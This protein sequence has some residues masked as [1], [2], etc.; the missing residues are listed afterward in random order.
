M[1]LPSR[2]G[3]VHMALGFFFI[4]IVVQ[5]ARVQLVNGN[6][7]QRRADRQQVRERE[8]P[9]PRG[10]ILDESGRVM[11]QNNDKVRLDITPREVRERQKLEGILLRARVP[12]PIVARIRDQ[13]LKNVTIPGT[14]L[15]ID[16]AGALGMKGVHVTPFVERAYSASR[17]ARQ[18]IGRVGQDGQ[19]IDGIELS[20]D[21]ILKGKPGLATLVQDVS[22]RTFE[23]PTAP[24]ISPAEGNTV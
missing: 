16:V 1:K 3:V 8:I 10:R 9:A 17:A 11:A 12:S 20:L 23:S 19:P 4:A 15:R 2:L 18:I 7:W 22:R 5:A 24:G 21:N 6:A 13:R 14:F